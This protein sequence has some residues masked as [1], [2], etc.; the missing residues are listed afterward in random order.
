[1][2]DRFLLI[3]ARL[4]LL[5]LLLAAG[6]VWAQAQPEGTGDAEQ[7]IE[8]YSAEQ[9]EQ[10]VAELGAREFASRE[11]AADELT[12]IGTAI[13]PRLRRVAASSDDPEIRLRATEIVR[14]LSE[15]NLQAKVEG[16]L[17]GDDVDFEGWRGIRSIFGDTPGAR[18]LFVELMRQHPT[19]APSLEKETRDRAVALESVLANVQNAMTVE[20]RFPNRADVFALLLAGLDANIPNN[21]TLESQMLMVLNQNPVAGIRRDWQ[22]SRPF[23]SLLAVW[24]MRSSL[25]IRQELIDTGLRMDLKPTLELAL[26]TLKESDQGSVLATALQAI[27]RYGDQRHAFLVRDLLND[28]RRIAAAGI[29]N[30]N[31]MTTQVRDFAMVAIAILFKRPLEEFGFRDVELHPTIGFD[32]TNVGFKTDEEREAA[33]GKIEKLFP[34][35]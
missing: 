16:F 4:W 35:V 22:L 28:D 1:M 12:G 2:P 33:L 11:R 23:D 30:G 5:S 20:H 3:F 19:L 14:Q 17:A 8:G 27:S 32:L 26:Q 6:T 31:G 34:G 13:I 29:P 24:M 15:G 25:A 21:A 7:P 9:I 18:E 10:L